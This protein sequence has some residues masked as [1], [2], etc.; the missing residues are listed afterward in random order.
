MANVNQR[1]KGF[2][3]EQSKIRVLAIAM[4]LKNGQTISTSQILRKLKLQ[5]GMT[6]DR[7]TIYSDMYAINMIIP[8]EGVPG[9]YGGYR[10]VD[11]LGGCEDG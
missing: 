7:K 4:M 5:Y 6:V 8:I 1:Q 11:V 2:S 3:K 9:R 10:K